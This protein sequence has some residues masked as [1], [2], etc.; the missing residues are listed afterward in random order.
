[1]SRT[2]LQEGDFTLL[3]VLYNGSMQ[4]ITTLLGSG[5]GGTQGPQG[6]IGPIGPQGPS[7]INGLD[8]TNGVDG[9]DGSGLILQL[10]GVTQTATTLNFLQNNAA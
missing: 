3:N 4:D 6:P 8:G 1:M 7:G 2:N 9:Q 5:G 10:D